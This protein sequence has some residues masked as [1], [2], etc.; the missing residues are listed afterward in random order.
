MFAVLHSRGLGYLHGIWAHGKVKVKRIQ[1]SIKCSVKSDTDEE[2]DDAGLVSP[3]GEALRN[4][5]LLEI[6]GSLCWHPYAIQ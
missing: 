5:R 3:V 2:K 1:R 4:K 6:E